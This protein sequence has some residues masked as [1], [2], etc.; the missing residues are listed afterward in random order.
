MKA[1]LSIDLQLHL[2]SRIVFY[3]FIHFSWAESLFG[4]SMHSI[5]QICRDGVETFLNDKVRWLVVVVISTTSLKVGQQV[6][7]QLAVGFRV[8][9]LLVPVFSVS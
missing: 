4:T 1:I 7:G 8:I 9:D 5:R 2:F 3:I 6:K